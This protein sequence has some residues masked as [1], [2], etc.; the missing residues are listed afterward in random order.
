MLNA[1]IME[2][3]CSDK[4]VIMES[5]VMEHVKIIGLVQ[6]VKNVEVQNVFQFASMYIWIEIYLTISTFI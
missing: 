1:I 3:V 6:M 4:N 5:V 2:I